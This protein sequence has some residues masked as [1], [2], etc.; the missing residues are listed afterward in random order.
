[1]LTPT[2]KF[3]FEGR[4]PSTN[5]S[6][7]YCKTHVFMTD[8]TKKWKTAA[9]EVVRQTIRACQNRAAFPIEG[10]VALKIVYGMKNCDRRDLD[11]CLKSTI[12]CLQE[13]G[14]LV[15]D[16]NVIEIHA[17]KF[18]SK[19]EVTTVEVFSFVAQRHV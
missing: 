15:D 4:A 9:K 8:K 13:G 6:Y 12:D 18:F 19:E 5:S 3:V 14:A 10:K 1:M 16:K 17:R 11:N 7:Y 2:I